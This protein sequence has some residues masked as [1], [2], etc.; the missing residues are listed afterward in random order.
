MSESVDQYVEKVAGKHLINGSWESSSASETIESVDPSTETT[1]GVVAAGTQDD[2]DAA[3][4]AARTSFDD[5]RWR[6]LSHFEKEKILGNVV[7][8][9]E[10]HREQLVELDVIDSGTPRWQAELEFEA[11]LD[12]WRYY[13]G[14]PSK[15]C[16]DIPPERGTTQVQVRREPVGVC[17]SIIPWNAPATMTHW[18]VAPALATGNSL[19]LKPAEQAPFGPMYLGEIF[20][21]AGVPEGVVNIL[22]GGPETGEA[23]IKHKGINKIAFTGSVSVAKE[24]IRASADI[25]PRLTLEL[26]GKSPSVVFEDANLEA[27]T[28]GV[29]MYGMVK[30]GQACAAGSR[31]LV[32][33]SIADAFTAMLQGAC[34]ALTMGAASEGHMLGPLITSE[35]REKVLSY[36]ELGTSEGANLIEGGVAAQGEGYFVKPTLFTDVDPKSR[37]AQE[38]IF[39]PVLSIIPFDTEEEALSLAN[40]TEYGLSA[41]VWTQNLSR[42]MRMSN[43][44]RAGTVWVNT[45]MESDVTLPFGGFG[46]SGVG[47][48]HGR[49]FL[50]AYTE[51]KAVVISLA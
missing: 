38:E 25:L 31:V 28:P 20:L 29:L 12:T 23:L 3:V 34:Q 5:K 16:G 8:V 10:A 43:D 14:W 15:I 35:H 49:A 2:V 4:E 6:G 47:R 44:I 42:A 24:I 48:E 50:E 33:R 18:K 39:G 37:I 32:Q 19:V 11:G 17:G 40:D 36:I 13:A 46:Q 41:S 26:G 45:A 27:A 51:N 7:K 9:M 22:S 1:I 30:S 21:E